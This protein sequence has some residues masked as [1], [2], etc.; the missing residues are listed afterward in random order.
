M[1]EQIT[2]MPTREGAELAYDFAM[3]AGTTMKGYQ[4]AVALNTLER[5]PSLRLRALGS[6]AVEAPESIAPT[7]K[8]FVNDNDPEVASAAREV[9]KGVELRTTIQDVNGILEKGDSAIRPDVVATNRR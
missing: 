8:K 1:A 3:K 6:L 5:V 2:R 4:R 7:V 9:L